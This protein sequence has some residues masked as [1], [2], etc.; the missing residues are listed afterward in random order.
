[1]NEGRRKGG[2]PLNGRYWFS[3]LPSQFTKTWIDKKN[4]Q[5]HD[6]EREKEELWMMERTLYISGQWEERQG[7][8]GRKENMG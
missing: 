8:R 7:E 5:D 1:M 6:K 3:F 2:S 4:A